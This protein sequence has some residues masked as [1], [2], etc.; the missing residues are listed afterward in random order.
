MPGSAAV[1]ALRAECL[2]GP[3]ACVDLETTGGLAAH[4]R[5]IEVGI[6]L[7]EGGAIVEEWSSLVHPGLRIPSPIAAFT[8]ID[9]TMVADAPRFEDVAAEVKRRLEGRLFVAHNAR[10]DY[11]FLRTEFRRLGLRFSAPVLC[12]VRLSRA[13]YAEHAR[14]NLDTLMER[15]GLACAARHRALGDAQVLPELLAAMER[16]RGVDTLQD[17]VTAA[18]RTP[19]L[20][21]HLPAELADDLP[22]GPGVY[23][24]RDENGAPLYVGKGRNIRSRVFGHFAGEHR[25]GKDSKLGREVRQVE[26]IETGGELGALLLESRLVRELAP[27]GNRRLRRSGDD[28]VVRLAPFA[29]GL[30]PE[31]VRLEDAAFEDESA[32]FGPFRSEKDAWRAIE[33]KAREA[34]L[35][36]KV[37]G[38]ER[39]EGSCVA[40]QVGKCR[41]ACIGRE[42]RALHDARLQITLASL[43]LKP[44]PF[45]GPIG[46]RERAPDASGSCVHV[47]DR[48]RHLGTARSEREV[49]DVL[50]HGAHGGFDV[51]GYRIIGRALRDV[52]PRDL[53]SFARPADVP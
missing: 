21:A 41:G 27:S 5:I 51:D 16:H 23:L 39:G 24:F 17:A 49:H 43:R 37:M 9:D 3:V 22:D 50:R 31:V 48:W 28:C 25:S 40:C 8:G 32:V 34:G 44:W 29:G 47:L 38:L 10:F 18:L 26:W 36:L 53:L 2:R 14:H 1:L 13:L 52:R 12:T 6:V 19:R 7:L 42:P 20:P 11:G 4:H 30:V 45:P 35:C 46:I 33:G 15:F